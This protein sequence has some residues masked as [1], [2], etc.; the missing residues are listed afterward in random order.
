MLVKATEWYPGKRTTACGWCGE[1][2]RQTHFVA[3][4]AVVL[5]CVPDALLSRTSTRWTTRSKRMNRQEERKHPFRGSDPRDCSRGTS[6]QTGPR[7]PGSYS[8][9]LA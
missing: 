6:G 5:G 2:V 4:E 8:D 3:D 9:R 7:G 1:E